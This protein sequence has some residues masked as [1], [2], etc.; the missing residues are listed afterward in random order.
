MTTSHST[1]DA[2]YTKCNVA[3]A[4]DKL[5]DVSELIVCLV[6]HAN[7]QQMQ[8]GKCTL[9]AKVESHHAQTVVRHYLGLQAAGS[10]S[11]GCIFFIREFLADAPY[12]IYGTLVPYQ[13]VL[14]LLPA[15]SW[16]AQLQADHLG[17]DSGQW[18]T[19]K[20]EMPTRMALANALGV[21][22]RSGHLE[23]SAR[24]CM[25]T[26]Y[27]ACRQVP[28]ACKHRQSRLVYAVCF[29]AATYPA[30]PR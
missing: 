30:S 8:H 11:K 29:A 6:L 3:S 1:N 13:C 9:Q 19:T 21:A 10:W 23:Q 7:I 12:R 16:A 27:R 14:H 15:K 4:L 25:Y 20:N 2:P 18:R 17:L 24:T 5:V 26:L 28:L 22:G